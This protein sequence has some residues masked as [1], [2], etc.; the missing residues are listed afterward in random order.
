[1]IDQPTIHCQGNMI[2]NAAFAIEAMLRQALQS[3]GHASLMVSG[4]SSPKPLYERLSKVD[5]DWSNVTVGLVDERWVDPG[6]PG[7][8]EDFIREH[9]IQNKAVSANFFGLKTKHTTVTAGLKTAEMRFQKVQCPFDV[10]VMGMG[11]DAHTASWFPNSKGLDT[12][13]ALDNQNI[14]C[15]VDAAAAP[16]AGDHPH[17][18]TLTLRAV[19]D[20]H[21]VVL[22]IPG[23]AKRGVFDAAPA[24]AL[25]DAPVQALLRAG[26]N[27]HVFA[28]PAS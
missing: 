12:A 15:A 13:L 27:L 1:M 8:N 3:R 23:E 9:L 20:A 16:V 5:L 2:A 17:R 26:H 24:K 14:L 22:F 7:S 10:C 4:G 25:S 21:A 28:S 19:L 18:I 11:S 6:Q